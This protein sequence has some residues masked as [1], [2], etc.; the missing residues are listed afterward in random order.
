MQVF[1]FFSCV[2][3]KRGGGGVWSEGFLVETGETVETG[4]KSRNV[5]QSHDLFCKE[6]LGKIDAKECGKG[7]SM[8]SI[9]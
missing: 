4:N 2:P 1:L 9:A 5:S 7:Q 8:N 3:A 6:S